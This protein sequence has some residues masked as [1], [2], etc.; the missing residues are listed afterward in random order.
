MQRK[1]LNLIGREQQMG[2]DPSLFQYLCDRPSRVENTLTDGLAYLLRT[3]GWARIA[4]AGIL[5]ERSGTVLP[6]GF[7]CEPQYQFDEGPRPDLALLNFRDRSIFALLELK[8]DAVLTPNQ[9]EGY[10]QCILNER[11]LGGAAGEIILFIVPTKRL[12]ELREQIESRYSY[13][14]HSRFCL[15]SRGV[16]ISFIGWDEFL[17]RL[18]NCEVDLEA[19][20]I[21]SVMKVKTTESLNPEIPA[22]NPA[23]LRD[24]SLASEIL[25]YMQ[26]AQMITG[27]LEAASDETFDSLVPHKKRNDGHGYTF[28]GRYYQFHDYE[29]FWIGFS[30]EDWERRGISPLWIVLE[31]DGASNDT[32]P[33]LNSTFS[34]LIEQNE[35]FL[36]TDP[37]IALKLPIR[38][39]ADRSGDELVSAAL[40]Q[41]ARVLKL[42]LSSQVTE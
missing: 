8:I 32:G 17:S 18:S 7:E 29:W 24:Q 36:D 11:K 19:Q 9:P 34:A 14:R 16:T 6:G 15:V 26:L 5:V 4:L 22:I 37:R 23:L 28:T 21:M 3:R 20:E 31:S 25:H 38:L 33:A 27:K 12:K 13:D 42:L 40:E 1:T 39:E 35:A 41:I 2:N 10:L 30:P